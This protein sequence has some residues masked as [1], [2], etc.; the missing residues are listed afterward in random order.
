[1]RIRLKILESEESFMLAC[2][3][4]RVE[5]HI[6][7]QVQPTK[8]NEVAEK[9]HIT[10]ATFNTKQQH[11]QRRGGGTAAE[12]FR[13][14][15]CVSLHGRE[16]SGAASAN[17]FNTAETEWKTLLSIGEKWAARNDKLSRAPAVLTGLS[18]ERR[19][20]GGRG[21]VQETETFSVGGIML[22]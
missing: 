3:P 22:A 14:H 15:M 10:V 2:W 17:A 11:T 8:M 9:T 13:L 18:E 12:V 4:T 20:E 7:K 19:E 6:W 1:M 5:L 16:H 21:R